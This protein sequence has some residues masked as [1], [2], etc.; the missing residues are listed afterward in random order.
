MTGNRVATQRGATFRA[1]LERER[2]RGIAFSGKY[3]GPDHATLS[4]AALIRL[5]VNQEGFSD[6]LD[7]Y[8]DWQCEPT[9]RREAAPRL[10]HVR[11]QIMHVAGHDTTRRTYRRCDVSR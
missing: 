11:D 7:D 6:K 1:N 5:A 3:N 8:R 10:M 2:E 4:F 9:G